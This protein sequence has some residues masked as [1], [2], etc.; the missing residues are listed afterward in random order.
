MKARRPAIADDTVF[1]S[2]YTRDAG[3]SNTV[4]LQNKLHKLRIECLAVAYSLSEGYIWQHETFD[5]SPHNSDSSSTSR[6]C[7]CAF[8]TLVDEEDGETSSVTTPSSLSPHLHGKL[9]YGDNIEDEWFVVFLLFS[10]SRNFPEL[11]VRVWDTDGEFLLIE[12]AYSIPRWLKPENS[13]NRVFIRNGELHILPLPS[14]P[15]ELFQIPLLPSLEDAIRVL[16][17][18]NF[19]TRADD[20]VQA[21]IARRL[22]GFQQNSNRNMHT[23]VCRV[24]LSVAQILKH[25]NQLV[26]LAVQAFY[27]RDV[28]SMKAA[29]KMAYFLPSGNEV[30]MVDVMV[31]MS[32]AMYAQLTQQVFQ[33]PRC[34]PMPQLSDPHYGRAEIG[35]KLTCGFEMMYWERCEY[36]TQGNAFT[37]VDRR[38]SKD[39]GWQTFLA[40]LQQTG[41]FKDLLEGSKEV[42]ERMDHA[43][44]SYRQ[45]SVFTRV[46]AAMT[47]PIQRMEE[48][49]ALQ[50]STE[51][52]PTLEDMRSD[53][54]S[55]LY[56]GEDDLRKAMLERQKEIQ[57]YENE[58]ALHKTTCKQ[59]ILNKKASK[60][61]FSGE[62][63]VQSMHAFINKISGFE[64]A[65]LPC[66]NAFINGE[67][68]SI[69]LRT[70]TFLKELKSAFGSEDLCNLSEEDNDS[71]NDM[72]MS[73][74]DEDYDAIDNDDVEAVERKVP[75]DENMPSTSSEHDFMEEYSDVLS[76]ELWSSSLSRSFVK[77]EETA[78]NMER[79]PSVSID[80]NLLQ[81]LLASYSSQHGLPGPASNLL[82]AMGLHLPEDKDK[83]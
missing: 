16:H 64:G 71:W 15:A 2:L 37:G 42:R 26:A 21:A 23:A 29:A 22:S 69:T 32:R 30:Q 56:D 31:R 11:F 66:D 76:K 18:A 25:E 67:N 3:E 12:A 54:E 35:M 81:N 45:T 1:F 34:Y 40:S 39:V 27:D 62:K 19:Q 51:D 79:L 55:W 77:S 63:V 44:F 78:E 4:E 13:W 6:S 36:K 60:G 52:F 65:E 82:G 14:S 80:T 61:D 59:D 74:S 20:S 43:L 9:R 46:S 17:G 73:S 47:A 72:E 58:R 41:Y 53:D 7:P 83:S 75:V 57:T 38:G 28:D 10:I 33:A 49:L 8:P 68:D 70:E 5:I 50:Y 24:P 48:I